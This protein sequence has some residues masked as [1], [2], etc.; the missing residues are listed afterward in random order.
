MKLLHLFPGPLFAILSFTV[1]GPFLSEAQPSATAFR[2]AQPG[3]GTNREYATDVAVDPAGNSHAIGKIHGGPAQF[4]SV[5]L[6]NEG[7]FVATYDANGTVVWAKGIEVGATSANELGFNIATD[8]AGNTY[9]GGLF[10]FVTLDFG[11]TILA[12]SNYDLFLAK[13]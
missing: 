3:G 6:T 10:A 9:V 1:L 2:W 11:G 8:D 13:Y 4:S 12:T 5:T 7:L